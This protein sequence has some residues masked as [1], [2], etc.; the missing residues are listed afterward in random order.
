MCAGDGGKK[1]FLVEQLL[2]VPELTA[3]KVLGPSQA[4]VAHP[5][6]PSYLGG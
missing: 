3:E 4:L 1:D 5:C 6:N 2:K